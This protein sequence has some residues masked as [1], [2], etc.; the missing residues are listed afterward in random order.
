MSL[1]CILS[2]LRFLLDMYWSQLAYYSFSSIC[3]HRFKGWVLL[4]FNSLS[5]P[6]CKPL[7]RIFVCIYIIIL[8]LLFLR[9]LCLLYLLALHS[10][11][12]LLGRHPYSFLD[13]SSSHST[14]HL[15]HDCVMHPHDPSIGLPYWFL[16]LYQIHTSHSMCPDQL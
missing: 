5:F 11:S 10:F 6:K 2:C 1:C 14:P 8:V 3:Y 4:L 15:C 13:G 16:F 7:S 12:L 9:G